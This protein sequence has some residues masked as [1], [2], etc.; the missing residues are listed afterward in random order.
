[1][2]IIAFPEPR[3]AWGHPAVPPGGFSGAWGG[4]SK[5]AGLGNFSYH[6]PVSPTSSVPVKRANN[7]RIL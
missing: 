7:A 4:Q 1:M 2:F 5:V 3:T 6:L